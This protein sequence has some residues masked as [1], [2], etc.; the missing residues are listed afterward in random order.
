[1]DG[2]RDESGLFGLAG[3]PRAA[4]VAC[5]GLNA[6]HDRGD[7]AAGLV[8]S[9]G[10]ALRAWRALGNV[11][12]VF[13]GPPIEALVGRSAIGQV[14][15]VTTPEALTGPVPDVPVSAR[16]RGGRVAIAM[17]GRLTNGQRLRRELE[18]KGAV[19]STAADA[20]VMLHL[21]AQSGQRTLVN[22]LV[23]ALWKAEGAFAL[24]V[25]TE[26]RLVAVR[27]A[28]GFRPLVVGRIDGAT[29]FASEG[30]AIRA[31][32][33][34]VLR[35]VEPGEMVIVDASGAQSVAPF[36]R[37]A[38]AACLHE[39]VALARP[40]A[41]VF[42]VS[43]HAERAALGARLASDQPCP[44]AEVV[45]ALPGEG[46]AAATGFARTARLP[47]E[48]GLVA[49]AGVALRA[50]IAPGEPVVEPGTAMVAIPGLSGRR[51]ALVCA[52]LVTGETQGQAVSALRRAGAAE[53][54]VRVASA[55]VRAGCPYGVASPTADEIAKGDATA[56]AELTKRIGA[57]SLGFL[58]L[59]ALRA[60][61]A[62]GQGGFCDGCFSGDWPIVPER[63][64][65]LPLFDETD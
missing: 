39:L 14:T 53:V 9:D 61:S 37:R 33:G 25:L 48:H 50:G 43:V 10:Y 52:S 19:L 6:L 58:S 4:R 27:D 17:A 49:S 11:A 15:R 29:A 51:I 23:D 1:M 54:H 41:T 24:L 26:D 13:A 8:S 65:Q 40:E 60:G 44:R 3:H 46:I 20:E 57:D 62:R 63:D 18:D 42:G 5:V 28:R 59:E 55:P 2:F 35:E 38:R 30:G 12:E 16:I 22:R 34:E 47:L 32:G 45:V 21:I 64:G 7:G 31:A 36:P 56:L